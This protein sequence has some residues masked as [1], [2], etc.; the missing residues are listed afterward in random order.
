MILEYYFDLRKKLNLKVNWVKVPNNR[1]VL[2][3]FDVADEGHDFE[4]WD[5]LDSLNQDLLSPNY[6]HFA[7]QNISYY[8]HP[9]VKSAER[10]SAEFTGVLVSVASFTSMAASKF[11]IFFF[12]SLFFALI[13]TLT[14][15]D[16]A[17]EEVV[18]ESDN[19]EAFRIEVDKLTSKIQSLGLPSLL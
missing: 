2:H 1:Q 18:V 8:S 7:P 12:V 13:F 16:S 17:V 5:R 9:K 10:N 14:E 4:H 11:H 19:S 3:D 15:A 6:F